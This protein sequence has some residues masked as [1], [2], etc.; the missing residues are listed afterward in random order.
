[1]S[2]VRLE[3]VVDKS[4][5]VLCGGPNDCALAVDGKKGDQPCW[6]VSET[7]PASLLEAATAKDDGA[8]CVCRQC[9]ESS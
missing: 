4:R 1:M 6:C 8:S 9:L 7:F 3:V 5:C 2:D